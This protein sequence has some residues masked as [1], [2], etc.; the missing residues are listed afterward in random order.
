MLNRIKQEDRKRDGII[1][2]ALFFFFCHF[3]IKK[4][5]R[6]HLFSFVFPA[7]FSLAKIAQL[8][9]RSGILV[10]QMHTDLDHHNAL[11]IREQADKMI[12]EFSLIMYCKLGQLLLANRVPDKSFQGNTVY[13]LYSLFEI[14]TL[15]QE[16]ASKGLDSIPELL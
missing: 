2:S 13:N 15:Y 6:I 9:V 4:E 11:W 8:C 7:P 3:K 16:A 14:M 12:E 5:R 1:S 10:I